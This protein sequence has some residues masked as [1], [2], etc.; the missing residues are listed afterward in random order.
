MKNLAS[1]YNEKFFELETRTAISSA[2]EVLP[3]LFSYLKKKPS[4]VVDIGCGTGAWLSTISSM[5]VDDFI[6]LDGSYVSRERLLIPQNRFVEKDLSSNFCIDRRFDLAICLEVAEHIS[7]ELSEGFVKNITS[8]S[9][10]ILFSAGVPGQ[11]GTNHVNEQWPIYWSHLFSTFDFTMIDVIR[12][13]IWENENI[14]FWYR[15]NIFIICRNNQIQKSLNGIAL[16]KNPLMSLVHPKLFEQ[17]IRELDRRC[18]S[19]IGKIQSMI[20]RLIDKH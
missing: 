9:D 3:I 16:D 18:Q 11:G 2:K 19:R 10:I 14:S 12:P 1:I 5:G 20:W 6:G 4:S 8:I 13:N 15:Q 7:P 17:K